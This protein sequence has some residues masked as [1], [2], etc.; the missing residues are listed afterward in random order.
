LS[1]N[2]SKVMTQYA[3]YGVRLNYVIFPIDFRDLRHALA[4]NGYELSSVRGPIP[5]PPIRIGFTGDIA[6]KG[7][8]TVIIETDSGEISVTGRSLQKVKTA[9]E[10][11]TDLIKRELGVSLD[12]NI[13][14]YLC[15]L[16]CKTDTGK[17]PRDEIAK[18]ENRDFFSRLGQVLGVDVAP[19]SIRL[20]PKGAIPNH[21][22]WFDISIEPDTVNE[23]MYHLGVVFRSPDKEKTETFVRDLESNILKLIKVIEA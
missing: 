18:A 23:K 4:K 6:R 11:L 8:T 16:H 2:E 10:E 7:E 5:S 13:K 1:N 15:H 19:F 21:E 17:I 20:C 3:S 22:N 9:F 14:Y 12:L